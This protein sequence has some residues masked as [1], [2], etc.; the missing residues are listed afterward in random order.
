MGRTFSLCGQGTRE[1]DG[2]WGR[3]DQARTIIGASGIQFQCLNLR[4]GGLSGLFSTMTGAM[5]ISIP[6]PARGA[7]RG[8]SSHRAPELFQFPPLR[9]GRQQLRLEATPDAQFQFPPLREGRRRDQRTEK[10]FNSRPCERGDRADAPG[11]NVSQISIPAP[12]RGATA[13]HL[14]IVEV[15][16]D[17][18]SRPCERGDV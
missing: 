1:N 8:K 17:F 5:S 15:L 13:Q 14:H 12:A 4:E 2:S 11:H 7:T 18:N 9:E 16:T 3:G 10:H 6:A